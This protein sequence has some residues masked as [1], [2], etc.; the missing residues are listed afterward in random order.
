MFEPALSYLPS[1]TR[2]GYVDVL[3]L[4]PQTLAAPALDDSPSAAINA[5]KSY[6]IVRNDGRIDQLVFN[7]VC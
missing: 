2:H 4:L 3:L 7:K 6:R 5:I 1:L